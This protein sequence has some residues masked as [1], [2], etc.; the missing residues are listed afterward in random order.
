MKNKTL[1]IIISIIIILLLLL[2]IIFVLKNRS[3][4]D[5]VL[6]LDS[7]KSNSEYQY[8]EI[9]WGSSA[10]QVSKHLPYSLE[11]DTSKTP[12]PDNVAFY[13][14]KNRYLLDEQSSFASFEFYNDK[15][16]IV[17]FDFHLGENY[18]QWFENQVEKL[19]QLYGP[20]SDKMES[21]SGQLKSI[22]Y[23]WET[24]H[25]MLQLILMTGDTIKPTATL[26]VGT[27]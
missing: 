10:N 17:K 20:E 5:A 16:T 9:E 4:D 27:K 8:S 23:K 6:S 14:S 18:N 19:T 11:K 2:A 21:S 12:L 24:D 3:Y 22:G 13:K 15:L 25:T 7:F 26:G 1:K